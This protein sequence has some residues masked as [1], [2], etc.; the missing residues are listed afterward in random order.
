ME[1]AKIDWKNLEWKFVEDKAYEQINAPKWFDFL[2]PDQNSVDDQAWF[3]RPECKHPKTAEDF[4]KSS[5][6]KKVSSPAVVSEVSPLGDKI[7]RD[8]KLKRRGLTQSSIYPIN[9]SRVQEDSENQNPNLSTP[10]INQAKA[11]KATI[12]SS[13]EKKQPIESTP[14][15][16]E[17]LPRL[18]STLS[19]RN[20]F[21][22]RDILNQLTDFCSELKRMAMR[23]REKEDVEG[24]DVRKSLGGLKEEEV[25]KKEECNGEVLGEL[26]GRQT[27]RMPL[28]EVGKGK[29]RRQTERMPFLEVGKG[30]TQRQTENMPL[31]EV[32][33]EGM[34]GSIIKEK[35]RRNKRIDETE[36]IPI[37]LNLESVKRKGGECLLQI[38]TNPPS[39]QCFSA[40]RP[41]S[42]LTPSQA[43]KSKLMERGILA[44]AEQN[45]KV[46]KENS[47]EKG[48]TACI[49]DGREARTMD[50]F[51]FLKPC[52]TLSN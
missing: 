19:A 47:T 33:T 48:K 40:P 37:S 27:E 7:Q 45:N 50:V 6:P 24:L 13:A 28:L 38:R 5:P 29:T 18:R 8:V 31:L 9:N 41:P 51:W 30:K 1:P 34:E 11:M 43:S 15:N 36:N 25:V 46:T 12:K 2:N 39:P 32:K 10:P 35:Q 22:G 4:L 26:N 3:C 44:D 52:T 23:A 16:S 14:Q 42:K 49:V 20:L 17:V 21:A